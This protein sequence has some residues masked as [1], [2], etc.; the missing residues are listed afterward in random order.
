ML[1]R[2]PFRGTTPGKTLSTGPEDLGVAGRAQEQFRS[3]VIRGRHGGQS[4]AVAISRKVTI[5]PAGAAVRCL[6]NRIVRARAAGPVT[7]RFFDLSRRATPRLP[8]T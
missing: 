5:R 7:V 2:K 8:R 1:L 4:C 3:G 6:T